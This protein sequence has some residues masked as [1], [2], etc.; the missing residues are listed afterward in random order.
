MA[1][2]YEDQEFFMT[3][4]KSA[5]SDTKSFGNSG[6]VLE[7]LQRGWQSQKCKGMLVDCEAA[8]RDLGICVLLV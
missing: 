4:A 7:V 2:S 3:K 1:S 6:M 8:L 5:V